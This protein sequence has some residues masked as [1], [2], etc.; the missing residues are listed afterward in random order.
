MSEPRRS[1]VRR[2]VTTFL[3]PTLAVL[4]L[5]ASVAYVRAAAALRASV[6]ERLEAVATV[7]QSAF[8]SWVDHLHDDVILLS[9][10]PELRQ[11]A[12]DLAVESAV[13]DRQDALDRLS[14][15]L[16]LA[17]E[18]IP[19]FGEVFFLSANGGRVEASTEPAHE[20]GYRLDDRYFIE[21]RSGSFIQNVYP[22][23]V[24][25]APTLTISAPVQGDEGVV[26]VV[27]VHLSLDYLDH[28]ILGRSGLGRT[29]TV[30]LVDQYKVRVTGQR[31]GEEGLGAAGS[32]PAIDEVIRGES[33]SGL[34]S[35]PDGTEVL[36]VYHWLEER[37]LGL[38][39]EIDRREALAPARRL[40]LSILWAGSAFVVLSVAGVYLAARRIARPIL[41]ITGAAKEVGAGRLSVRAPVTTEDE[42]GALAGTFNRMVDQLAADAEARRRAEASREA[43]IA[44]L[45]SKN[46]ELERFTYTVSHDLKSP[47]LTIKGFAGYLKSDLERADTDRVRSDAERISAAAEK[48]GELLDELLEL[49]RIGRVVN[50]PEAVALDALARDVVD[51][52]TRRD[53]ATVVKIVVE[54]GLPVVYA[55]PVRL[56]EVLE[57]LVENA[58]RFM[59]DQ[60]A[61]RVEIGPLAGESCGFRVRD[62][63]VGIAPEYQETIFG[64]FERLEPSIEGTG[65]GLAIV[66]RIVEVHGGRVWVESEGVGRGCTFCVVLPAPRD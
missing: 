44:E 42:I 41:A 30:S 23:P 2:L 29:G 45:E 6:F 16:A 46:A 62:N 26:G 18:K 22:S 53:E 57:N 25:L 60:P 11:L 66:R 24:T 5:G 13:A 63:G 56:R 50:P 3:L 37:E 59:G 8:E 12:R 61:P 39:V 32:S 31:Y 19:G 49:S 4:V 7:K 55:D 38:I 1:L 20:G 40:A 36:G 15:L 28:S 33:G 54:E 65:V 10:L 47:L 51:A 14:G 9:Q 64:L 34:Y 48:M 27:A 21:G 35:R 43:L 58:C 17:L 52:I